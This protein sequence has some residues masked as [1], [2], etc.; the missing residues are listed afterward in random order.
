MK[1]KVH[2][3]GI[4][5]NLIVDIVEADYFEPLDNDFVCFIR[6]ASRIALYPDG[7]IIKVI[8]EEAEKDR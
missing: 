8:A 7:R 6:N 3:I 1:Y 5:G 2:Y 4:A